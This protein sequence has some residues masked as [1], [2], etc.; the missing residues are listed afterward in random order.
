MRLIYREIIS[1]VVKK[2]TIKS[3][4]NHVYS[5]FFYYKIENAVNW[6]VLNLSVYVC[7]CVV[8]P[9]TSTVELMPWKFRCHPIKIDVTNNSVF[10][11]IHYNGDNS[12]VFEALL[13]SVLIW[14]SQI[15]VY[16]LRLRVAS[17]KL[18]LRLSN[19]QLMPTN[20]QIQYCYLR[21]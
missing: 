9:M 20:L 12:I 19:L 10:F 18:N 11:W 2:R 8:S 15:P 14:W 16:L 4:S 6:E 5:D 1:H 13:A 21:L 7:A 17:E 3:Q